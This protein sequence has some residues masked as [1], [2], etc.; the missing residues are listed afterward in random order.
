M[1]TVTAVA[2]SEEGEMLVYLCCRPRSIAQFAYR[3]I[4]ADADGLV[5]IHDFEEARLIFSEL[6]DSK[7]DKDT[8]GVNA[9]DVIPSGEGESLPWRELWTTTYEQYNRASGLGR[10]KL[11]CADGSSG[12]YESSSVC[13]AWFVSAFRQFGTICL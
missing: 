9:L 13:G 1:A 6:V 12:K 11:G 10:N 4:T 7:A 3:L 5:N 2:F 8:S